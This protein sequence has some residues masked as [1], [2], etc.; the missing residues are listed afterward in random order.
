MKL[1]LDPK[2][3]DEITSKRISDL[4]KQV[5]SLERKLS[6]RDRTIQELQSKWKVSGKSVELIKQTASDLCDLLEDNDIVEYAR[7]GNTC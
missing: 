6:S 3:I 5:K 7:Y 4:E 2:Q 1:Q